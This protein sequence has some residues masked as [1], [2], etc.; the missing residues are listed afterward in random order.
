MG[1]IIPIL[2][3]ILKLLLTLKHILSDK[4]Q[5]M[6]YIA[7]SNWFVFVVKY[8]LLGSTEIVPLLNRQVLKILSFTRPLYL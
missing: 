1:F 7:L 3:L 6:F 8:S 4:T 5:K 2:L